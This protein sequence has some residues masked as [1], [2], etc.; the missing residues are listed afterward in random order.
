MTTDE[1]RADAGS[2]ADPSEAPA[3]AARKSSR[4]PILAVIAA[5]VVGA[6]SGLAVVARARRALA[7]DV[8]AAGSVTEP[9]PA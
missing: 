7:G 4:L 2:T 1:T 6:L 8:A 3:D 9:V 5:V